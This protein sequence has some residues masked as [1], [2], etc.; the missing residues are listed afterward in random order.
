MNGRI[1]DAELGRFLSPD[2]FVQVPEYSQNF[3]RY[4]YV[5]NNPLSYTDPTGHFIGGLHIAGQVVA[6]KATDK[7]LRDHP[8]LAQAVNI[9]ITVVLSIF[10]DP[11][12]AGAVGG[13]L[14]ARAV[15]GDFGDVAKGAAI[16]ALQ[17]AVSQYSLHGVGVETN[18]A[19]KAAYASPSA[20][21][22]GTAAASLAIHTAGHALVGGLH[23]RRWEVNLKMDSFLQ[24]Q[25]PLPSIWG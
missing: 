19:V 15:G 14:N 21:T 11:I 24:Q 12:T 25:L 16:G 2:P 9:V 20:S 7:Y 8:D 3:N 4:T 22:I 17:G 13:A 1:Y 6:M 18:V 10:T 23:L 5:L